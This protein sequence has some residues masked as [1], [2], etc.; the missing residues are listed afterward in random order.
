MVKSPKERTDYLSGSFGTWGAR[1]VAPAPSSGLSIAHPY[2][3]HIDNPFATKTPVW[4]QTGG[5]EVLFHEDVKLYEQMKSVESNKVE[6]HIEEE[7]PHDIILTG[8]LIGFEVEAGR[9]AKK[10]GE[11]WAGL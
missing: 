9:S 3:S 2:L 6:L 11:F 8:A 5:S 7:C 1:S 10:A 4:I